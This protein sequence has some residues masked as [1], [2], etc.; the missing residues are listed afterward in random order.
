MIAAWRAA[1]AKAPSR[2][3]GKTLALALLWA[4]SAGCAVGSSGVTRMAGGVRYEGRFIN[5]EAYAS[6]LQGVEQEARGKFNEALAAYLEAHAEDPDSPEIWARIGAVRCFEREPKAGPAAARAAFERGLKV[7]PGYYGTYFERA[8][9]AER[10]QDFAGA[11]R[12]A[13]AAVARRPEDEPGNL[14]VARALHALGQAREAREWLEAYRSYHPATRATERALESARGG[15]ANPPA[16]ERAAQAAARSEAFDE[17]RSGRTERAR[18]QAQLELEADPSNADAWIATLVACD[19]LH[20]EPCFEAAIS[21]LQ[22]PSLSP[23][24]TA[25]GYLRELLARRAGVPVSF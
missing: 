23:S 8:R 18:T 4:C 12:D 11:L 25:L 9:C 22:T 5:A 7:D 14:L 19:A 13:M 17:L 16:A 2:V 6:Y 21:R 1:Q 15:T 20:D 10:A 24:S 3:L